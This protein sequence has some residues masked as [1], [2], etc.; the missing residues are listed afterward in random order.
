[1]ASR[2]PVLAVGSNA[3][4]AQIRRKLAT[5]GKPTMVPITAV[6]VY[7]LSVGVS[8]HVSKAGYVPATPVLDPSAKSRIW[9]TWLAPEEVSVID[10]TEPNYNRVPVP[11]TC[12]VELMPDQPVSDCWLYMSRHGFLTQP[13]GEPRELIDQP[14]LISSLLEEVPLLANVAGI[15]PKEW[16]DRAQ[17]ERI[18][19]EI[20]ILFRSAGITRTSNLD[21]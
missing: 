14:D 17:N 9:V 7:G 13:S 5:A 11:A 21:G 8:A 12:F 15:S 3:A 1:M 16:V 19:D 10:E 2:I 18:R 4:P 6:T 20:R